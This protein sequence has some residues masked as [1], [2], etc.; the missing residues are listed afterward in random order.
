M[1]NLWAITLTMALFLASRTWL[2]FGAFCYHMA[3]FLAEHTEIALRAVPERNAACAAVLAMD[4]L[5][6]RDK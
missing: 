3:I 6:V 4:T 2:C 1:I 5:L